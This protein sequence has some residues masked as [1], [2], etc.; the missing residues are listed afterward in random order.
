MSRGSMTMTVTLKQK[1]TLPDGSR[2]SFHFQ[3][4][5]GKVRATSRPFWGGIMK[6]STTSTLLQ[7]R[8]YYIKVLRWLRDAVRSKWTQPWASG[9]GSFSSPLGFFGKTHITQVCQPPCSPNLAYCNFWLFPKLQSPLKG[10]RFVSAMVTQYISWLS[11]AS[12]PT[13]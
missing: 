11:G 2:P 3:R 5:H 7:A 4:R 1:L 13:D 8:Q 12:L 6:V 9:D 10:R